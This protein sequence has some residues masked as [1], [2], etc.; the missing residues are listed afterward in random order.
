[1]SPLLH[2]PSEIRHQAIDLALFGI[3]SSVSLTLKREDEIHPYISGNKFRKL[4]Y[5][6]LAVQVASASQILTF[7]GAFSN[8]I[9]AVA[10]AGKQSGIATLG[11]IRGEEL[12]CKVDEN[13]TLQ[14]AMQ[15]GMKL[16][17][18]TRD[19]YKLK[20]SKEFLLALKNKF[21]DF[22]LLPEGGTNALAIQGCA[23]ILTPA[24]AVF[25]II[26]A[27]V[28]TGGTLAGLCEG[29]HSGQRVL[30]Y[31]ALKGT[32]QRSEVIKYSQ[33]KNVEILDD[34]CFGGYAKID[35]PLIRFMNDFKTK[36]GIPLDP[37]YTA[38]MIYG[39]LDGIKNG[40]FKQ[41]SR[42][43]AIHTGGLQGIAGM[44]KRLL[45]KQLPH[46]E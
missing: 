20:E 29:A 31:S 28:G 3:N 27:P 18:V 24:D 25:D 22:Y 1:M 16:H 15:C 32:F 38:K 19:D 11:V 6:I 12:G 46:I 37:V 23:E 4:K 44:N 36:T 40:Y 33:N 10:A 42:I 5:N 14:Y 35:A 17:F 13:P 26:C 21:G 41:N 8:H 39:I 2:F 34:Y 9:A 45:K 30:G 43:L 7:G